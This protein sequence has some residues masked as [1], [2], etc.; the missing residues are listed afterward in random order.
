VWDV[1]GVVAIAGD[2][3]VTQLGPIV[4][5]LSSD[6]GRGQSSSS[7]D[8]CVHRRITVTGWWSD[9]VVHPTCASRGTSSRETKT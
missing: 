7:L 8:L 4:Y 5:G 6:D 3:V 9:N 1:W 2:S